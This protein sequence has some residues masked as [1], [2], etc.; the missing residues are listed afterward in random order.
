M[1]VTDFFGV[2]KFLLKKDNSPSYLIAVKKEKDSIRAFK[3]YASKAGIPK[4]FVH[5]FDKVA[6]R[7][8]RTTSKAVEK[9]FVD[10]DRIPMGILLLHL[11]TI[12]EVDLRNQFGFWKEHIICVEDAVTYTKLYISCF[13]HH[14]EK[15]CKM[16]LAEASNPPDKDIEKMKP[17]LSKIMLKAVNWKEV[18]AAINTNLKLAATKKVVKGAAGGNLYFLD[19]LERLIQ[20]EL[21]LVY[22]AL[23]K[24]KRDLP[25]FYKESPLGSSR[26]EDHHVRVAKAIGGHARSSHV[27]SCFE[28]NDTI[29]AGV[30]LLHLDSLS[31]KWLRRQYAFMMDFFPGLVLF[32]RRV[33]CFSAGDV[34]PLPCA[35]KVLEEY[36]KEATAFF[37]GEPQILLEPP[38]KTSSIY[39]DLKR[40][41]IDWEKVIASIRKKLE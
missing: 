20:A 24:T 33:Y 25:Y 40:A 19:V 11:A 9:Y 16:R 27:A 35:E 29:P 13:V 21:P 39:T 5:N 32:K 12:P 17:V 3:K 30:L 36:I 23:Q 22:F 10:G 4:E 31:E 41:N 38:H 14:L 2:V 28:K 34:V 18:V 7:L 1:L 26:F 6:K 15:L 37:A 8:F